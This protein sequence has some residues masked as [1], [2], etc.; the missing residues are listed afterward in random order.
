MFNSIALHI[1]IDLGVVL[2]TNVANGLLSAFHGELRELKAFQLH[3][4]KNIYY[5]LTNPAPRACVDL[6]RENDG[7]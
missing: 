6:R 2:V 3:L 7:Y 1:E 4:R 5:N